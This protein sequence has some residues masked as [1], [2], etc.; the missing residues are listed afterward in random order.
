M[1]LIVKRYLDKIFIDCNQIIG[2][3]VYPDMITHTT[4]LRI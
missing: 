2:F 3:T 4:A 1:V